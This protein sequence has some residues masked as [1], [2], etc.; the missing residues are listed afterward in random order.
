MENFW[1]FFGIFWNFL[2][3]FL[4]EFFLAEFFWRIFLKEFFWRIF[5]KEFFFGGFFQGSAADSSLCNTD[6]NLFTLDTY[7]FHHN[8]LF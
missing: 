4:E 2:E 7:I 8:I 1:N 5:L 3:D 6:M